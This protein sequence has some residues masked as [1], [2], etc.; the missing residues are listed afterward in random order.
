M[1]AE[2]AVR[3]RVPYQFM[4]RRRLDMLYALTI[5]AYY[6]FKSTYKTRLPAMGIAGQFSHLL[7]C[8]I[9]VQLHQIRLSGFLPPCQSQTLY[10]YL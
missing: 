6:Y 1:R 2:I 4:P 9:N 3:I 8:N 7:S 10:E 5:T